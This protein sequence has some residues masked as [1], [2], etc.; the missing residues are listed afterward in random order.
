M[1][2]V[3][4]PDKHLLYCVIQTTT[5][6]LGASL[7]RCAPGKTNTSHIPSCHHHCH[8]QQSTHPNYVEPVESQPPRHVTATPTEGKASLPRQTHMCIAATWL[9]MNAFYPSLA[10]YCSSSEYCPENSKPG[11]NH[12]DVC[13]LTQSLYALQMHRPILVHYLTHH[14]ATAP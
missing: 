2:Y 3:Y 7:T 9:R 8:Q 4:C 10:C 6:L 11:L 14:P 1:A 12:S 13:Y 5:V